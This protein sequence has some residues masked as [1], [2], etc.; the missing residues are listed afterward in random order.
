MIRDLPFIDQFSSPDM[1]HVHVMRSEIPRGK[2]ESI[3][4]EGASKK[5]HVIG[6]HDIPGK[7]R[8]SILGDEMPLLSNGTIE[9]EGEPVLLVAAHETDRLD[10]T[11]RHIRIS[12]ETDFSLL[13]FNPSSPDQTVASQQLKIGNPDRKFGKGSQIVEA[14]YHTSPEA[15]V[16]RA[17]LGA[18]TYFDDEGRIVVHTPTHWPMHVRSSVANVLGIDQKKIKVIQANPSPAYG[19]KVLFPSVLSAMA[20]VVTSISGLPARIILTP[21]EVE[22]LTTRKPP[23]EVRRTSVLDDKGKILAEKVNARFDVGAYPFFTKELLSRAIIAAG[24]FYEIPNLS[25]TVEAIRTSTSPMNL[26]RGLGVSQSLFATEVHFSRLAEFSQLNPGDWKKQHAVKKNII[27]GAQIPSMPLDLLLDKVIEESDF[28]RKHSSYELIRKRRNTIR[29]SRRSFRG[30]GIAAGFTGNGF[31]EKPSGNLNWGIRTILD[32]Q[33]ELTIYCGTMTIPRAIQE[34]WKRKAGEI[35]SIPVDSIKVA[36]GDTDILPD[37]GPMML[38]MP[39]AVYTSLVERCCN[40]IR[41][42]RFH[43]PLPIEVSRSITAPRK[44]TWDGEKMRGLPFHTISW[45]ALVTEVELDPLTLIPEIRGVWAAF[46]CGQIYDSQYAVSIAEGSIY[47]TLA[48]AMGE[49]KV[50]PRYNPDYSIEERNP[51]YMRLPAVSVSFE[52]TGRGIP[53]GINEIAESL[54]PSAFVTALSQSAG[55]YFDR[56]P[57]TSEII[58]GYLEEPA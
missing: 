24:S 3:I 36:E 41:K 29:A 21:Q 26:Y 10:K 23:V 57:M 31:T 45:G 4:T 44:S 6:A 49:D 5:V 17:P 32:R 22:R 16:N 50:T 9:Y 14:E 51:L 47:E 18:Y 43:T 1:L 39:V 30:I 35:L 33:D 58:Q 46:D 48:W 15:H 25:I 27:T 12:Y 34:L 7:N 2:I 38:A 55:V 19:E 42:Q 20:A 28:Y 54:V 11:E 40:H 13:A 37:S 53:G 56:I 52:N 8:I